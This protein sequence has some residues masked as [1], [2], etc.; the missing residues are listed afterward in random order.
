MAPTA[1]PTTGPT[2]ITTTTAPTPYVPPS[3]PPPNATEILA[4]CNADKA[5]LAVRVAALEAELDEVH[6]RLASIFSLSGRVSAHQS[7]RAA[8]KTAN[9]HDSLAAVIPDKTIDSYVAGRLARHKRRATSK[10]SGAAQRHATVGASSKRK[11]GAIKHAAVAVK[12]ASRKMDGKVRSSSVSSHKVPQPVKGQ[13]HPASTGEHAHSKAHTAMSTAP[14]SAAAKGGRSQKTLHTKTHKVKIAAPTG[15]AAKGGHSQ[16]GP[17]TKAHTAMS[18]APTSAAAKGGRSQKAL[19]T[20]AHKVKIAA[21][22]S[23]AAKGRHIHK[24]VQKRPHQRASSVDVGKSDAMGQ[25]DAV[26]PHSHTPP[27]PTKLLSKWRRN[28][29][30]K[31]KGKKQVT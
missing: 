3:P 26:A 30:G 22:T 11:G 10:T 23:A 15:A 1:V 14:T 20:Q 28:R 9:G 18:A 31:R 21:P 5:T 17:H 8:G 25:A 16:K 2:S 7:F 19:H 13:A 29:K 24:T 4:A 12:P 6:T 27:P